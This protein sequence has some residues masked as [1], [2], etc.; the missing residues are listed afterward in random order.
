[1]Q[2][3]TPS[4]SLMEKVISFIQRIE[5]NFCLELKAKV[6]LGMRKLLISKEN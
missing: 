2:Y 3:K 6:R 4:N 1:M 5:E